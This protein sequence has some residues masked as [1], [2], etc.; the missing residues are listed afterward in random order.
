MRAV[1]LWTEWCPRI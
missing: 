1:S